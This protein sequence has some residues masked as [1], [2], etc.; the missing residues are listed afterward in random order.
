MPGY[1]HEPL[2]EHLIHKLDAFIQR[3]VEDAIPKATLR[4]LRRSPTPPIEEPYEEDEAE[5]RDDEGEGT[6]TQRT[7]RPSNASTMSSVSI[8]SLKQLL[9]KQNEAPRSTSNWKDP[10]PFEVLRAV[11]RKDITFLME[12]RDRAF[13]LLLRKCGDATP[14]LHAMRIGQSHRD[15]AIVLLGAN[16]KLAI[17]FGLA[18]SQSDLTASFMQTLIMSQGDKWIH[19][20]I[21]DVSLALKAGT[22]GKPVH[23]AENAVRKFA[24]RELGKA[25]LIA[26]LED[27]V[28]NAT[29]DL[30]M[31]AAWSS[32]LA[33]VDDGEPIPTSYFARDDRVYKVFAERLDKHENTIRRTASKRLKWQ[34][35]VLRA[36]IEGRNNTY[37]RRVELLAGELDTGEGV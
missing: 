29:V 23:L 33:A 9:T 32:V 30:L 28:A 4:Q 2:I 35:R 14:L 22:E 25:E 3:E 21:T 7:R 31:M 6:D 5:G 13:H 12:I 27:Y 20:R 10:Q 37:R 11:E 34:L 15:V 24:T 36:V 1:N 18:K 19:N 17:D 26:S 8:K 16:L